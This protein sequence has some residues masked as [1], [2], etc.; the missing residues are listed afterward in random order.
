[1]FITIRSGIGSGIF[2]NGSLY[3]GHQEHAGE[4]GHMTV[5]KNGS[6]CAYADGK[7]VCRRK[8]IRTACTGII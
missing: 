6:L 7:A 4:I 1:M 8:S 5:K 2:L 3:Y